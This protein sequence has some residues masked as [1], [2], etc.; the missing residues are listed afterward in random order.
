MFK[1][2]ESGIISVGEPRDFLPLEDCEEI[3]R[4]FDRFSHGIL[5]GDD[6]DGQTVVYGGRTSESQEHN[7][8]LR[9]TMDE[10]GSDDKGHNRS[11]E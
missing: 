5:E 8:A 6:W 10:C 11:S 4:M 1:V 3:E 7:K 9:P 2:T